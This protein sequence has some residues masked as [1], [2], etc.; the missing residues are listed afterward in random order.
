M[1]KNEKTKLITEPGARKIIAQGLGK[2]DLDGQRVLILTPDHTRSGPMPLIF[3]LLAENL[4]PR[5][6]KLDFLIALGTHPAMKTQAINCLYGL[7]PALRQGKYKKIGI[8]NHHWERPE[9]F[10][11]LGVIPAAEIEQLSSGRMKQSVTVALNK[12]IFNY[13]HVII[14]G[15]VFPHEV[16]GFS[17]GHKYFF[18]GIAGPDII[19]LTHWLGALLTSFSI[20]G[21][22]DTPVRAVIERA[23][24]MVAL[25]R[26]GICS[27]VEGETG[28]SGLF[29]GEVKEAWRNAVDIS[30]KTHIQW[31][32]RPYRLVISVM[33]EMYDDLWTGAKGMYK[34]EPVVADGGEVIIYAPHIKEVSFTHGKLLD[35]V[36]YHC[37][38][39]FVKQWDQFYRYPWGVLAHSTHLRG[40]GTF[41]KG[42]E[43]SRI[44]VTLATGI[45]RARCEKL[46]LGYREPRLIHLADY[47]G[48]EDE[49]IKVAHRAGEILYR[50]KSNRD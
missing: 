8:F 34:L 18:P 49:G 20:I 37:R 23:A 30:R 35:R 44:K 32:D 24:E 36:G 48:R 41:E 7:T 27:V 33:P 46:G 11:K 25:P 45:P 29:V 9:T 5:V 28:L 50:L 4:L 40:M 10:C 39:Y 1:P 19:G 22:R 15:P 3:R 21:K 47:E 17:G 31:I 43:K 38:D 42:V 16:V 13:D 14:Y 2:A 6:A 26:T 12:L